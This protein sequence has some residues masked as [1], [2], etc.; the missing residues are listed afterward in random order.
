MDIDEASAE[1]LRRVA[2]CFETSPD[3]PEKFADTLEG[4]IKDGGLSIDEWIG[5][6]LRRLDDTVLVVL[7]K[8]SAGSN[9]DRGIPRIFLSTEGKS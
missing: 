5:K 9:K 2:S 6:I 3:K 1:F 4:V 8:D 7:L